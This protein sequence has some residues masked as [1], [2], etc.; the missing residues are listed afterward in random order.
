MELLFHIAL[1]P[2]GHTIIGWFF[3]HLSFMLPVK[4][5]RE[6]STLIAFNHPKPAYPVHILLVPKKALPGLGDLSPADDA[7]LLEVFQT[8]VSLAE[9]LNLSARGY[10]LI[11]NGGKYQ[12][13]PQLHFHLISEF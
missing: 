5:L 12:E 11:V 4:R 2:I 6:T 10:H 9:E 7:F 3:A 13:V 8:V 1:T